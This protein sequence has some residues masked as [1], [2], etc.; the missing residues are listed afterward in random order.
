MSVTEPTQIIKQ[1][2]VV[3]FIDWAK[4]PE[5]LQI[6]NNLGD[7]TEWVKSG[8]V[9]EVVVMNKDG[10]RVVLKPYKNGIFLEHSDAKSFLIQRVGEKL[11]KMAD[12]LKELTN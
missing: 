8:E 3:Y 1:N 11:K 5:L 9:V 10:N 12:K 2:Q 4:E 6:E 7:L